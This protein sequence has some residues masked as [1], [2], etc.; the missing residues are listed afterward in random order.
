MSRPYCYASHAGQANADTLTA[1][2]PNEDP[3]ALRLESSS[4]SMMRVTMMR[5]T[6]MRVQSYQLA[7]HPVETLSGTRD[8]LEAHYARRRLCL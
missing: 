7:F 6:M 2:G 4:R 1:K 8:I 3:E 5:A